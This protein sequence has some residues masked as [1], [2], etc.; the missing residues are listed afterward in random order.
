MDSSG[1]TTDAFAKDATATDGPATDGP[2][3]GEFV[4]GYYF[5][6]DGQVVKLDP[7]KMRELKH[8]F[9]DKCFCVQIWGPSHSFLGL[10]NYQNPEEMKRD[11]KILTNKIRENLMAEA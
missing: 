4:R 3:T 2:A 8:F 9:T 5:C 10:I 11:N 1:S 6:S 7:S